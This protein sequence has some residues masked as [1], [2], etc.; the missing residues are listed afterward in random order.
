MSRTSAVYHF[1]RLA[2]AIVL[3]Q[4][5]ALTGAACRSAVSDAEQS[6]TRA[7]AYT[8]GQP[9]TQSIPPHR[10][11]GRLRPAGRFR[12]GRGA[13]LLARRARRRHGQAASRG[14]RCARGVLG[15]DRTRPQ[16][17]QA[18]ARPAEAGG[19]PG[20][21][22]RRPDRAGADLVGGA[23]RPR[24][25]RGA[26]PGHAPGHRGAPPLSQRSLHH[27]QAAGMARDPRHQRERYG[28]HQRDPLRRQ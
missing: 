13:R 16:P 20:G 14:P 6:V 5:Q 22:R 18:A 4:K 11:Q 2:P 7:N 17:P 9:R 12:Q 23:R 28:R 8:H 24:H 15:L 3:L 10:R 21:R 1:S 25:R 19:E 27:R 26:D